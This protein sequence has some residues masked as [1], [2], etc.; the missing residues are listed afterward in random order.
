MRLYLFILLALPVVASA[1]Q[2][3]LPDAPPP[4]TVSQDN[5]PP[6]ASGQSTDANHVI[7]GGKSGKPEIK[8]V[9][10]GKDT[11]EEY[12]RH[13]KVYMIRVVPAIGRPYYLVDDN[14]DGQFRRRDLLSNGVQPPMWILK[15]W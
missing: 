10:H 1:G 13:G 4:P 12:S 6:A 2:S 9:P 14:G 8:T 11:W 7:T 15:Q 3:A 5:T